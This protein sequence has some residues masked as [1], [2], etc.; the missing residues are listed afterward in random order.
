MI[1]YCTYFDANYLDRGLLLYQSLRRSHAGEFRLFVLCLDNRCHDMLRRL[2]LD[3]LHPVR[4]A[5]LESADPELLSAKAGRTT[6]EYYFTT[7]PAFVLHLFDA[8]R[9]LDHLTYLDADMY[10]FS[11]PRP[12][13]ADLAGASI[14]IVPHRYGSGSSH[15]DRFGTYNVAFNY[16]KRSTEAIQCIR[17]WREQCIEWCHDRVENGRYAD[18]KY[19]DEWPERYP[20]VTVISHNGVNLAP[21]NVADHAISFHDGQTWVDGQPLICFH[22]HGLKR[23]V[24]PYYDPNVRRYGMRLSSGRPDRVTVHSSIH[25]TPRC[26]LIETAMIDR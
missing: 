10:F 5:D 23:L 13:F 11:D 14:G 20:G 2:E 19:L 8:H 26:P 17:R 4:L 12:V 21:W 24:G 6:V 3:G 7:T 1:N 25:T 16:F 15:A 18:Q 22:F 9:D